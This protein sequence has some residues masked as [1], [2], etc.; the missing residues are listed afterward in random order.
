MLLAKSRTM[1]DRSR[2]LRKAM[3]LGRFDE[4]QKAELQKLA[5]EKDLSGT[6][7]RPVTDAVAECRHLEP[8]EQTTAPILSARV[9]DEVEDWVMGWRHSFELQLAGIHPPGAM[10]LHGPTG[11]GKSTICG[12]LARRIKR[13]GVVMECHNMLESHLG[14]SG[15]RLAQAFKAAGKA[16]ALLVI[17]ELDALAPRRESGGLACQENTRITVA[18]MRMIEASGLPIVATT[19]R[20]EALDPAIVRRFDYKIEVPEMDEEIRH[21]IIKEAMGSLPEEIKNLPL[22]EALPKVRR[23]I[24]ARHIASIAD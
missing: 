3:Q 12:T 9:A 17:E 2:V 22:N 19:N 23:L 10:L 1:E 24:R 6:I 16:G 13:P 14:A 5:F 11:S 15:E 4:D 21:K 20:L 7:L 18:L 8:L